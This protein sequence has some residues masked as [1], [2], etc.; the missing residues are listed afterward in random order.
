MVILAGWCRYYSG[1]SQYKDIALKF[2]FR[3]PVNANYN[4][5]LRLQSS[6]VSRQY[7]LDDK[8]ISTTPH[9]GVLNA[10]SN[11]PNILVAFT[12]W[13]DDASPIEEYFLQVCPMRAGAVLTEQHGNDHLG[14]E[15]C[16]KDQSWKHANVHF[17][18]RHTPT[19]A[20]FTVTL[21]KEGLW[22]VELIVKDAATNIRKARRLV[23]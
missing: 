12:G 4:N 16:L 17:D 20:P 14:E 18:S 13:G 9:A 22:A 21:K 10:L 15:Y 6:F 8:L 7:D 19:P 11:S 23:M 5:L 2:D 1:L 3:P